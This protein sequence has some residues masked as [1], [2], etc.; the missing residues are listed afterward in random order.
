MPLVLTMTKKWSYR[1]KRVRISR[2]DDNPAIEACLSFGDARRRTIRSFRTLPHP[3]TVRGSLC[4][5]P[6]LSSSS[7]TDL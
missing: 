3:R 2:L 7:M 4:I 1:W 5:P 6:S